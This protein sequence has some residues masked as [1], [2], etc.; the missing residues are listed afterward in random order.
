[1]NKA[2]TTTI[3]SASANPSVVGQPVTFTATVTVSS[4]GGGT[5]T[6]PVIFR[7]GVTTLGTRAVNPAGV[8]TFTTSSLGAGLHS[9]TASYGGSGSFNASASATLTQNVQ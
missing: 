8:A 6:G 4:P 9:V 1:V 2:A 7:D 5:P 3:V